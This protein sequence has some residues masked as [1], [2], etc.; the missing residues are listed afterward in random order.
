MRLTTQPIAAEIR[1]GIRL[2]R[3]RNNTIHTMSGVM[4]VRRHK[5][6]FPAHLV[7]F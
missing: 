2:I 1:I 6:S 7:T 4:S 3:S 5:R